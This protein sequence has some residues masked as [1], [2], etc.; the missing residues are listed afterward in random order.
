MFEQLINSASEKF[1]W[2]ELAFQELHLEQ[3]GN[4][5]REKQNSQIRSRE[6][7]W[8]SGGQIGFKSRIVGIELLSGEVGNYEKR[9]DGISLE[10]WKSWWRSPRA[11]M[12]QGNNYRY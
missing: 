11:K 10:E 7:S 2:F 8:G 6:E 3:W 4:R 9:E 12:G 5:K 1:L